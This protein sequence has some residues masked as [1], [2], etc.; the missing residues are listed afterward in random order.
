VAKVVFMGDTR[1][2]VGSDDGEVEIDA[3]TVMML[4]RKIGELYPALKPIIETGFAVSIDGQ[5]YEDALFQPI[6][7][8]SEVV[9]IPKIAGG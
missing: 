3:P 1:Q 9:L 7:P 8:D 2:Y 4:F 5:I 6:K